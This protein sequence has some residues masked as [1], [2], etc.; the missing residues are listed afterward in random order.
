MDI[1]LASHNENKVKEISQLLEPLGIRV[2]SLNDFSLQPP[3]ETGNDFKQNSF[4][5]AMYAFENTGLPSLGDDSGF[6]VDSLND[7]PGLCS[8]R[9]AEALG[10]YESAFEILNKCIN[11]E[12]EKCHF[13]TSLS[14]IYKHEETIKS[15]Y[16]EG[17]VNG[18]FTYPARGSNGFGYCPVFTP[19]GFSQTFSELSDD[20]RTKINHRYKALEKFVVF[21]KNCGKKL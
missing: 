19:D 2:K 18:L 17:R 11:P 20:V 5:K 3:E 4:I 7:F 15:E 12:N 1:V 8:A 6:C 16:F 13:V 21:M 14:F 10:S 9:F